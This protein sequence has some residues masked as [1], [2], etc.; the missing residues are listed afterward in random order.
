MISLIVAI[1]EKRTI[2]LKG[3]IPWRNPEDLK[4]FKNYTMG[5]KVVMGRKTFEGLPKK[6]KGREIYVVSRKID[7]ENNINDLKSF[8][9]SYKDSNEEIVVAG[10]GEIYA[11]AMDYADKIVLSIILDNDVIGDTFFPDIDENIFTIKNQTVYDTFKCITY[12][13]KDA[14]K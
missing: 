5:K 4:H 6:L 13:R 11:Q 2:G 9:E 10:G 14:E 12:E 3:V 7:D 1:N 8:L